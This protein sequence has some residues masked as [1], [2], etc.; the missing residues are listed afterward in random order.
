MISVVK[1]GVTASSNPA[2]PFNIQNSSKFNLD[3]D[4]IWVEDPV[5]YGYNVLTPGNAL[6]VN[7]PNSNIQSGI[8]SVVFTFTP[9]TTTTYPTIAHFLDKKDNIEHTTTLTGE[10]CSPAITSTDQNRQ[11]DC[12][13]PILVEVSFKNVGQQ[14]DSIV[15]VVSSDNTHFGNPLLGD[16]QGGSLSVPL[17]FDIDQTI[18]ASVLFSPKDSTSGCFNDTIYLIHPNGDTAASAVATACAV[19]RSYDVTNG[20]VDFG[21][22]P[23]GNPKQQKIFSLCSTGDDPLTVSEIDPVPTND[24]AITLTGVYKVNGTVIPSLPII[25]KKGECLDFEV[26]FDPSFELGVAK[27][28]LFTIRTN[29]F[30]KDSTTSADGETTSGSPLI[31]GFALDAILSCN[32]SDSF[33]YVNNKELVTKTI[34]SA[35]IDG[36][37]AAKFT[38][39]QTFPVQILSGNKGP[40]KIGFDPN[41]GI[42]SNSY[43]ATVHVIVSDGTRKD[44]LKVLVGG[45]T[46]NFS[47]GVTSAFTKTGLH[48]GDAAPL[49]IDLNL[50]KNGLTASLSSLDIRTVVLSYTYD[51]DLLDLSPD[52]TKIFSST[53]GWIVD[54][55][56][57]SLPTTANP[58]LR[59]VLNRATPLSDADLMLGTVNF[60]ATLPKTAPSSLMT[61]TELTLLNSNKDTVHTCL[62]TTHIDTSI[63]IIY[64]CGDSTLFK[65]MNGGQIS[66][67]IAPAT[68]NPITAANRTETLRYQLRREG[69]VSV[70]IFDE[71]GNQVAAIE[72]NVH[73]PAGSF[74]VYYDTGKLPSGSYIYRFTFDGKD[75]RSGRLVIE[76]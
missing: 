71:L 21:P 44:T 74:E 22:V 3:I 69:S 9:T 65:F 57:S 66:F 29:T 51:I 63:T 41:G 6:P 31:E 37:D 75:T 13:V 1:P 47:L 53:P 15:K 72:D 56:A 12:D 19:Y 68:P 40:I 67:G 14:A 55:V 42:G 11:S 32:D 17:H 34:D 10:G 28:G 38:L 59:L 27:T 76:R 26:Q 16:G 39:K 70:A 54:P 45:K 64:K 49:D 5:H 48:F 25:L 60:T 33:V 52:I 73:H 36:T 46:N 23:F 30:G 35:W 4:S 8:K 24:G 7:V 18:V 43:T 2:K 58:Q 20:Y 61:L 50:N 62:V